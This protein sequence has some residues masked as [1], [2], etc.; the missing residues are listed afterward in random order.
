MQ[1][2]DLKQTMEKIKSLEMEK[3]N[4]PE[5]IEELKKLADA[6][7]AT[8]ENEVATL[9]EES[10]SIKNLIDLNIPSSGQVKKT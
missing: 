6:K 4:L 7:A 1:M 3:Q 2:S 8:L 9:R 5:E 10:K